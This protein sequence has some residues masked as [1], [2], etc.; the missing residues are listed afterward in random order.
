MRV[1]MAEDD[2]RLGN[3]VYQMLKRHD[4][5]IDWVQS[6]DDA[7]ELTKKDAYDVIILDWMMPEK[8]GLQVCRELRQEHYSGGILMLTA[9]D[10]VDDLE[11]GLASGADDYIVKPFEFRVLMAR[12]RSVARRSN[13]PYKEEKITV[14]DLELNSW[15]KIAR[16]GNRS[17]QLTN[18]EFQLLE[19]LMHNCGQI[20]PKDVI[21]DRIWGLENDV[22]SNN[23]EALV[24]L[25]R[26]KVDLPGEAQLIHNIRSVG[27]KMEGKDACRD[28]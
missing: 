1:L 8:S 26:K 17:I 2:K 7:L 12:I 22:S 16:R 24:R 15:T 11:V 13:V 27:Y 19:L 14:K 23:L 3:L 5:S 20:L 25:L 18:R 28:S 9:K 10:T 21:M 6:G 4:M